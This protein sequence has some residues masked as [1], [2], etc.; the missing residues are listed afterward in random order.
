MDTNPLF[1]AALGL[2]SPWKVVST[3]FDP[4]AKRLDL[5]IDFA[6]GSR[7]VCPECGAK[8]CPVHDTVEKTWRHLDFFQ[9]QA[10]LTA[11]V[12][13]VCC[14]ACGTRLVAVP[15][16]R[17]GS[18][19]TLLM[20]ALILELARNMPVLA[21]SRLLGVDDK[22]VWRVVRHYVD[23]AVARIDA[24]GVCAVGVDE[25]A[26]RKHHDYVTLFFDLNQRRLLHVA[27]G[28]DHST[29]AS[30][31]G[32]LRDHGGRPEQVQDV[33]CDLSAAF[34]KGIAEHLPA[35]ATTAD[36]F[37]IAKL[38]GDALDTVRRTE[39]RQDK[40]LKG[41]RYLVLK[42][43]K[44]LTS[45][46]R[47]LLDQAIA[48]NASLAEA[49]RLKETFRDLYRQPNW[50]A[51][52]GFLKAWTTM[53]TASGIAPMIRAANTIRDHWSSILRWFHSGLNNGIMEALNSLIQAAKR[54]AR[55]Y[56]QHD[57][58]RRIAFLIAGKLDMRLPTL[59]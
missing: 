29:V 45:A 41:C 10:Y 19:F 5:R 42:D 40:T 44:R 13:R 26:A 6:T 31:A 46:Q 12:P 39:W 21:I 32:F 48:R 22:T 15:W 18:G 43:P 7:F 51:G 25:T 24:S 58:F 56:R 52:R 4:V 28:K 11:R 57:T 37:H 16:A 23:Q 27:D 30:F 55:G 2:E 38:L 53:A 33:S 34:K 36:R 17:A 59:R 1:S 49:Y 54:K 47:Q 50:H 20:E 35:A 3:S 14:T 8:R 9:H